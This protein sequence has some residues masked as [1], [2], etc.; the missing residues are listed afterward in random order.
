MVVS[1]EEAEAEAVA[2]NTKNPMDGAGGVENAVSIV[3]GI[4]NG[5]W[6]T[7]GL[8][9]VGAGVDAVS[10]AANPLG[11]L[12]S[13]GVGYIIEHVEFIKEPFDALMGNPDEISGMASTWEK[14]GEE[15]KS[16]GQEYAQSV[17]STTGWEGQAAEAYRN[18]GGDG[19]KTI[20]A[21][22]ISSTGLKAAVDGA[23]TVVAAVRGIVRDLIAGAIGEII[24]A[25]AKWGIAAVCTAGIALGGAIADA[26]RIALQWAEKISGWMQKLGTTLKNLW[27]K[28][29]ELGTA[30]TSVR[31]GVDEFF[32]GLY[33][34][35]EG[36][37]V[38]VQNQNT[39]LTAGKVDELA[40]GATGSGTK[41]NDAWE[42]AKAGGSGYKPFARGDIWQPNLDPGPGGG[43]YKFAYEVV[44]ETA[45]L[46]DGKD[47]EGK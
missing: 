30:A 21:L 20:D 23:G 36:N 47:Q 8:S 22:A 17:R 10:L 12:A 15:L 27:N 28:L 34:P 45:K 35:P 31:K 33:K 44:K 9:A 19:A 24:A 32:S 46:D 2:K 7:V 3:K 43:S 18:L 42:G 16:V 25:L 1:G 40:E 41:L 13:W 5:D 29:D 6:D 14:I 4:Q 11:T 38:K 26:V 37:L 39:P